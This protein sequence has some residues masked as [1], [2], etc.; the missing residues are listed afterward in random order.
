M[1]RLQSDNA[2]DPLDLY[3]QEI[4]LFDLLT[5]KEEHVLG[6]KVFRFI[7]RAELERKLRQRDERYKGGQLFNQISQRLEQVREE[8]EKARTDMINANLR[9]V[10]SIVRKKYTYRELPFLDLVQEGNKGLIRAVEKFDFR[11]RYK[12]STYATRWI[13]QSI[14]RGLADTSRM[15]RLPVNKVN[16]LTKLRRKIE[17][18]QGENQCPPTD[19]ELA[20]LTKLSAEKVRELRNINTAETLSL[21][22]PIGGDGKT[23]F[24]DVIESPGP[25]LEELASQAFLSEEIGEILASLSDRERTVLEMRRGLRGC[26]PHTLEET[27]REP[28]FNVTRERIR[29]IEKKAIKQLLEDS[30]VKRLKEDYYDE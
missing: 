26:R 8:G 18:F 12:F 11:K 3:C 29:Q 30:R 28:E 20:I 14:V 10:V 9:L 27:A 24:G 19:E 1:A 23:S 22:V 2:L 13:R 4:I 21:D 25:G 6:K 16:D 15:I 5:A 7:R 17:I